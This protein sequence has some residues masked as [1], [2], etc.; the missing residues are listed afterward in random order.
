MRAKEVLAAQ[1]ATLYRVAGWG[2][3]PRFPLE[4]NPMGRTLN[5]AARRLTSTSSFAWG[6]GATA[7]DNDVHVVNNPLSRAAHG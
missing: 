7:R 4:T 6:G 3:S 2:L 5:S 1:C